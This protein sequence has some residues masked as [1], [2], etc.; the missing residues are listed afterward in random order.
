MLLQKLAAIAAGGRSDTPKFEE[1]IH[2][3]QRF[4][5]SLAGFA[6]YL[7]GRNM[8]FRGMVLVLDNGVGKPFF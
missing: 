2:I 8:N 7:G 3:V 1:R 6:T 5:N 4:C